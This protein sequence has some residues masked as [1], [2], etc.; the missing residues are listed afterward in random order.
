MDGQVNAPTST[1]RRGNRAIRFVIVLGLVLAAIVG[2]QA[3]RGYQQ[4]QRDYRIETQDTQAIGKVIVSTF[5]TQNALKVRTLTGVVQS[6]AATT[7]GLGNI[8]RADKVVKQPFS[9]DYFVDMGALTLKDYAWDARNRTLSIRAPE[10]KP[11]TPNI[12]ESRKTVNITRG[13]FVTRDMMEMLDRQIAVG[14]R[15]QTAAEAA[16]PDNL[17][18]ARAAAAEAIAAN[19]RAPLQAAG[20]AD[21]KIEIVPR[22]PT[23]IGQRDERWDV[24]RSIADVLA[25]GNGT[26]K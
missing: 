2:L 1:P 8:L 19:L 23:M 7:G 17:A 15:N 13:V 6:T 9:V 24:S 18:A 4:R 14:A 10:V 26:E 16:K 5:D 20:I 3:F 12:D 11:A 22:K 21:V 25:Q